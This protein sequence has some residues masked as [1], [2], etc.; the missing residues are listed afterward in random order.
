MRNRFND[1]D[2]K[3]GRPSKLDIYIALKP[4]LEVLILIRILKD[5]TIILFGKN[6]R[7]LI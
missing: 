7:K 4:S 2:V 1:I 3:Y 5:Y 6:G